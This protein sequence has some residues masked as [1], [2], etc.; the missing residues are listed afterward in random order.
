MARRRVSSFQVGAAG[1][2]FGFALSD[3]W[4]PRVAA[5]FNLR[6][7]SRRAVNTAELLSSA[8]C[9]VRVSDY[10]KSSSAIV[11]DRETASDRKNQNRDGLASKSAFAAWT[12]GGVRLHA[13]VDAGAIGG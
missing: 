2:W 11:S 10:R 5:N 9:D 8:H 12:R 3:A 6:A 1:S 13:V 7:A 4:I